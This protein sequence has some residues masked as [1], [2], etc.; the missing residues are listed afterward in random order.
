MTKKIIQFSA[1]IDGVT[2]KKD[3][4]L[5]IKL[6]TQELGPKDT[7]II[8]DFGNKQIWNAICE[9]ELTKE[10]IEIPKEIQEFKNSKSSSERM[11]NVLFI[12]WQQFH[13]KTYPDF[14]DFRKMQ[15][16][17]FI[18]AVKEKLN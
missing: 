5:S 7:A 8:F 3:G 1:M 2:K 4:T 16:E 10:Q 15:M 12:Y 18:D 14:E 6:G 9:T 13:K 11:R 17:K